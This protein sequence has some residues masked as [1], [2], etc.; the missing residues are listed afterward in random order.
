MHSLPHKKLK[1]IYLFF[2][3]LFFTSCENKNY[4]ED[5]WDPNSESEPTPTISRVSPADSAYSGVGEITIYGT[6]FSADSTKNHVFFNSSKADIISA[7]DTAITVNPP[8]LLADSIVIKVSVQGAYLFAE[9]TPYKLYSAIMNYGN[10]D[11]ID[12]KMWG[13]TID[14]DENVY[15]GKESFPEGK[16]DKLTPPNGD[17]TSN[18]LT[19][20]LSKPV[21]IRKGTDGYI[22]YLDGITPYIVRNNISSGGVS[23]ASLPGA[24]IDLD[25]DENGNLY[26]GGNGKEIYRVSSSFAVSTVAAYDDINIKALRV[27]NGFLYVAGTYTGQDTTIA[28]VGVW[29]NEILSSSGTLGEK[30]LVLDW[31]STVGS[32]T[33]ILAITFDEDGIMY[34]APDFGDAVTMIKT[35]G[36]IEA[37]YPKIL[38]SP[39]HKL[40][41]G[42]GEYLY[43]NYQGD[44]KGIYRLSMGKNGAPRYGR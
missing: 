22:Y 5:I 24:A 11:P 13:I 29:K 28:I 21:S 42:T 19:L 10:Y 38:S 25:F 2:T 32:S 12:D 3:F 8:A 44:D 30:E 39:I 37:L 18:V 15:V 41:W 4:P 34:I 27:Y 26:C 17:V 7:S 31:A 14:S 9:F 35:D 16:I 1:I 36:S 6:N 33:N 40:C 20:A 43:F 23:Y